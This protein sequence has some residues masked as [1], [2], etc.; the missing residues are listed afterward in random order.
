MD[1]SVEGVTNIMVDLFERISASRLH[2]REQYGGQRRVAGGGWPSEWPSAWPS[3]GG[4]PARKYEYSST[5]CL[6]TRAYGK[7][8]YWNLRYDVCTPFCDIGMI[9]AFEVALRGGEW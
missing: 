4:A 9:Y 3:G 7:K 8:L 2:V 6:S 5:A 1:R